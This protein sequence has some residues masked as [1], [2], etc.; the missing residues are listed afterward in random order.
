LGVAALLALDV[1]RRSSLRSYLI[2]GAFASTLVAALAL[3]VTILDV[4]EGYI[5]PT[6]AHVFW[7][8]LHEGAVVVFGLALIASFASGLVGAWVVWSIRWRRPLL[9]RAHAQ[10]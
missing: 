9:G 10:T 7:R 6:A 3:W 5:R 8:W 2:A 1:L 4:S